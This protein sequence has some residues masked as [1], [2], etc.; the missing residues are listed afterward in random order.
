M[1]IKIIWLCCSIAIFTG[2]DNSFGSTISTHI[3]EGGDS[4]LI[5]CIEVSDFPIAINSSTPV[6]DLLLPLVIDWNREVLPI[7][8]G[9]PQNTKYRVV[10]SCYF[11]QWNGLVE[12]TAHS[13]TIETLWA[14]V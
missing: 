13:A 8:A 1:V 2:P 12:V 7:T 10:G 4:R 3:S 6:Y 14:G 5:K 9:W 11:S